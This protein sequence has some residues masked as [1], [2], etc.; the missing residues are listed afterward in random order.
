MRGRLAVAAATLAATAGLAIPATAGAATEFGDACPTTNGIT[1]SYGL[2]EISAPGNPLPAASP[3]SGV[4]TKWLIDVAPGLPEPAPVTL[5]TLRPVS[6]TETLLVTGESQGTIN[7][8][9]NVF[10]VRIPIEAG[11][12]LGIKGT[13][14]LGTPVCTTSGE[15]TFGFFFAETSPGSTNLYGKT[16]GPYRIPVH[17]FVEPDADNDG[18]GDETQDQCPQNGSVQGPCPLVIVDASPL[19]GKSSVVVYVA[20]DTEAPVEV[21]GVVNLGKGKKANLKAG[22]KAVAPGSIQRFKLKFPAT[23]KRR[24]QDLPRKQKLTLR[25]TASATN[26]AGAISTDT[27]KAKLKGQAKG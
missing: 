7:V 21:N 1:A 2:F 16:E 18:F 15:S 6:G 4:L 5:K 27:A 8:G 12:R 13:S 11:D 23:L 24:L 25:I 22:P 10:G 9:N 3:V 17:G 26:V 20:T 14:S 19:A